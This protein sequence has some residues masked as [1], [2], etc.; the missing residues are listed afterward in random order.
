MTKVHFGEK[1][2]KMFL[3]KLNTDIIKYFSTFRESNV[4]SGAKTMQ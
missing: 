4:T 3:G 1:Q 2:K